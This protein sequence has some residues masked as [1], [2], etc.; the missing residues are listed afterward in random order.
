MRTLVFYISGHGFG[1]ASRDIE[2]INALLA[3]WPDLRIIVRTSAPKWLFD[4]TVRSTGLT[5]PVEYHHL[6]TDTGIAQIDSLHLDV[7]ET[8]RRARSFMDGF[9]EAVTSEVALLRQVD[10]D[11]VVA[12]IPPLGIAAATAAAIPSIALGNFTWDWIYSA[13]PETERLIESIGGHYR[14]AEL[15]LRLPMHGGFSTFTM[16]RDLPFIARRSRRDPVETRRA[17]GFP[18]EE[19][20]VLVSFGGYGLDGLN[21]DALSCLKGYVA[22]VSD[23]VPLADRGGQ[24]LNLSPSPSPCGE[25]RGSLQFVNEPAMYA[26]GLRYEDV[27]RAVDVVVTKPGYGIIAE[28]LANDTALLYTSRGHFIEYDVLTRDAPRFL[29][30]AYIDHDDLFHGTWTRHLDAVLS[31]SAPLDRPAVDGADVAAELLLERIEGRLP[32]A[33]DAQESIGNDS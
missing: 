26:A 29:R 24:V 15:A 1:H 23:S 9:D 32:V 18:L 33:S 25:R 8:V 21:L 19:R 11:L 5:P 4:L 2:V 31:Q 22:L 27:V 7:E 13:Y 10:A 17:M 16:I 12:D 3:R 20:L 28:C 14:S 6:E 30:T